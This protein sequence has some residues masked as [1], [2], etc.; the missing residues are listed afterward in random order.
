MFRYDN[1][2]YKSYTW[3]VKPDN[4]FCI[5]D[6]TKLESWIPMMEWLE[7]Y[8][9]KTKLVAPKEFTYGQSGEV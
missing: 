1:S 9:E 4:T 6:P 8:D 7:V 2:H 3:V 5:H